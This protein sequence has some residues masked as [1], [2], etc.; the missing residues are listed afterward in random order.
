MA[1]AGQGGGE[2]EWWNETAP[3]PLFT[4]VA[5]ALERRHRA[6]QTWAEALATLVPG[7]DCCD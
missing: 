4:L 1:G 5:D 6:G 3:L 7:T 2:G